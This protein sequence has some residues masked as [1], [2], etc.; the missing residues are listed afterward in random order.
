MINADL[1]RGNTNPTYRST[2][3]KQKTDYLLSCTLDKMSD[4]YDLSERVEVSEQSN[5]VEVILE[6]R[7]HL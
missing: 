5:K 2:T 3:K 7:K 4:K 6:V 1:Q